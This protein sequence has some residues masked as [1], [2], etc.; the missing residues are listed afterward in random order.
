MRIRRGA[1]EMTPAGAVRRLGLPHRLQTLGRGV[2]RNHCTTAGVRTGLRAGYGMRLTVTICLFV[3]TWRWTLG[4]R[5]GAGSK[6]GWK[7][8]KATSSASRNSEVSRDS[9]DGRRRVQVA[10]TAWEVCRA[11]DGRLPA[12]AGVQRPAA[13]LR[14]SGCPEDRAFLRSPARPS[15]VYDTARFSRRDDRGRTFQRRE[16]R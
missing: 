1:R 6:P 8:R 12:R 14:A 5:F 15:G 9:V 16:C 2:R 10:M 4:M 13:E 11:R 3:W 7:P